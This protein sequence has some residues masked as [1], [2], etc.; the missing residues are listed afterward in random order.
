MKI[1]VGSDHFGYPLKED[2]KVYLQELG[3]EADDLGC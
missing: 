1:V 2:L 3:H